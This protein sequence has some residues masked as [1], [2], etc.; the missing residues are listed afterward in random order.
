[1]ITDLNHG[2][3]RSAVTG[4][5][6]ALLV[7]SPLQVAGHRSLVLNPLTFR[8]QEAR[9]LGLSRPDVV[10]WGKNRRICQV[11]RLRARQGTIVVANL[12]STGNA[13]RR[14]ADAELQ[15]A[16]TFVDGFAEPNE[17]VILAGDFNLTVRGSRMISA[18]MSREWGFD[19]PTAS[20]I[21]HVL[22]RGIAAGAP[23]RWDLERR[24]FGGRVL[25]DHAPVDREVG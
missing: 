6:N 11:L 3:L 7:A 2:L 23:V 10:R 15:R 24:T 16:A 17:P 1:V 12:H 20:G 5:G 21:D 9:R 22:V 25:S 19:G 14:L 18:L 4:Q 13:D 8:R